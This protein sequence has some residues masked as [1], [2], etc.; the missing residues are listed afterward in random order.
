M[1]A[2]ALRKDLGHLQRNISSVLKERHLD[3][4]HGF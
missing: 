4:D 1:V 3:Q 2:S